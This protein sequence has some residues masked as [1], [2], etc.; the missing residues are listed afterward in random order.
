M[1]QKADYLQ[2]GKEVNGMRPWAL[3]SDSLGPP[4]SS[5]FYHISVPEYSNVVLF[6][7]L[8]VFTNVR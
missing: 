1:H 5:C 6:L 2:I 7:D 3:S 4:D 8:R